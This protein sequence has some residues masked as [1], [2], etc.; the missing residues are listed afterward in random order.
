MKIQFIGADHEV[1]GSCHFLEVGGK[2]LL[3]DCGMEQG[4][5]LYVNQE[6]PVNPSMID[7]ILITHAHIDHSGLLP[8]IYS[9]GFR[10]KIFATEATTNLCSIMLRDSAHIQMFEAEWKNRKAKRSGKPQIEP[11]YTLEDA[12]N[13]MNKFVP[14]DY[15]HRIEV[16]EGV[17]INFVDA[18]H[19][20]GSSSIEVWLTEGEETRKLVFSGDIGNETK[21]LIRNPQMVDDADIVIMESTYGDKNHGARVDYSIALANTIR[22]TFSRG[23]NLVIP[24][25]SVGRTQELLYFIRKIKTENRL[26]EYEGFQVYIDSPLAVEATGIFQKSVSQC[27]DEE[28]LE[29]VNS[30]INPISFPGLVTASSAEESKAINFL[31]KPVIIISASGMCEAG[32][33]RHHLKH[34]LWRP[35]STILFVGYQVPGTL[36]HMLLNGAKEVKLFGENI[37]V[38][39]QILNLPG[40]SGHADQEHLLEWVNHISPKP[41]KVFVVHGEDEV[42][43]SFSKLL[44]KDGFDAYAPYSG[45]AFDLVTL[46]QVSYGSKEKIKVTKKASSKASSNAFARLLAAGERLLSV[47][48]KCEGRPNKELGQFADQINSLADKWEK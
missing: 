7:A 25:F 40:I 32:R 8:L 27:F 10:G 43:E 6:I 39:A 15:N 21:P 36:G 22:N 41:K 20:L 48:K 45:D 16:F 14:C 23:G 29:L 5:E 11:M 26:P 30:G 42:V 28:A 4:A 46:E 3:V 34:N 33:I 17:E 13:V 31:K 38:Q 18:G 24:A 37:H 9:R 2:H 47:I 1:T 35:E 44:S 19:L 12:A